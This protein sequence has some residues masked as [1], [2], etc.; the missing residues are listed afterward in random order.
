[1]KTLDLISKIASIIASG[2]IFVAMLSYFYNKERNNTLTVVDQISFFREKVL[3]EGKVLTF[4]VDEVDRENVFKRIKLDSTSSKE[5]RQKYP[6]EVKKQID[7]VKKYKTFHQQLKVLDLLE[8]LSLRII[9]SKTPKHK[10]L[11]SIK[12]AFIHLVEINVAVLLDQRE[13]ST[14]NEIY[15]GVIELYNLWVDQ[16][17][18]R[19][20]EERIAELINNN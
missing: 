7:L 9:Y 11:K 12:P 14:G 13:V 4:M 10:A 8:E 19:T 17:D 2:S 20:P 16:V 5:I 6:E 15:S 1:M 3:A 18:R